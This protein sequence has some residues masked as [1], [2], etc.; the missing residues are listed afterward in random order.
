MLGVHQVHVSCI[1]L[2]AGGKYWH[3]RYSWLLSYA[4]AEMPIQHKITSKHIASPSRFLFGIQRSEMRSGDSHSTA[5]RLASCAGCAARDSRNAVREDCLKVHSSQCSLCSDQTTLQGME[6]ASAASAQESNA[7]PSDTA[8]PVLTATID[9]LNS[10]RKKHEVC[11]HALRLAVIHT[12]GTSK[13]IWSELCWTQIGK[14]AV[15]TAILM[16]NRKY[17]KLMLQKD[18]KI[19]EILVLSLDLV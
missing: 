2:S 5:S 18:T 9:P 12:V 16:L 3:S 19:Q 17:W 15:I 10:A 14:V 4:S 8:T 7:T 13:E 1:M 6:G 11:Q